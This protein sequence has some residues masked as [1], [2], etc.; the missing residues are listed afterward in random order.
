MRGIGARTIQLFDRR[1]YRDA[2]RNRN[3]RAHRGGSS[4]RRG[5]PRGS[6]RVGAAL[7]MD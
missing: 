2:I 4:G 5:R 7:S 3:V 6:G 1:V